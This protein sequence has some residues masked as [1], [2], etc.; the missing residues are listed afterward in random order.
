MVT[1]LTTMI[2]GEDDGIVSGTELGFQGVEYGPHGGIRF[3]HGKAVEE[4]HPPEDVPVPVG[5]RQMH[6]HQVRTMIFE[7]ASDVLRCSTG[8]PAAITSRND[9]VVEGRRREDVVELALA[10]ERSRGEAVGSRDIEDRWNRDAPTIAHP[11]VV[12]GDPVNARKR[13]GE[14]RRVGR[15]RDA[16]RDRERRE[17]KTSFRDQALDVAGAVTLDGVGAKAVDGD[18]NDMRRL[19]RAPGRTARSRH[20][21]FRWSTGDRRP[22]MND[23]AVGDTGREQHEESRAAYQSA[24]SL[25]IAF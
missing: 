16:G 4:G 18:H 13:A 12:P 25:H 1:P 17:R 20:R 14:H 6:E 24:E 19:R 7:V 11:V 22:D 15:Q 8:R 9:V 3:S 23:G 10:R 2:R 5:L 21:R